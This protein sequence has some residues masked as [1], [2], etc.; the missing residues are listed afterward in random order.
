M[1]KV[2]GPPLRT[3]RFR[4]EEVAGG[5]DLVGDVYEGPPEIFA[6]KFRRIEVYSYAVTGVICSVY[7]YLA[8]PP[9]V[10]IEGLRA[11]VPGAWTMTRWQ[12]KDC[13]G[14]AESYPVEPSSTGDL[15]I[16]E[17]R[18]KGLSFT[19]SARVIQIQAEPLETIF[20]RGRCP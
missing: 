19:P 7:V 11:A 13:P 3:L 2:L 6:L 5:R 14:L 10:R 16:W 18:E 15:I 20:A 17:N 12:M 9:E 4:E 8:Y 1:I